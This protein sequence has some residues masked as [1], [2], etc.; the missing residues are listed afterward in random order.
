[1]FQIQT[2]MEWMDMIDKPGHLSMSIY[3]E[4]K[5]LKAHLLKYLQEL[6]PNKNILHVDDYSKV[7]EEFKTKKEA[8]GLHNT[9]IIH[10]DVYHPLKVS[11]KIA[12]TLG[13]NGYI[14]ELI[15]NS[16]DDFLAKN[17]V[18]SYYQY[19][20][21][22]I[23]D[24]K[25][26]QKVLELDVGY[27]TLDVVSAAVLFRLTLRTF[28]DNFEK[29]NL[30]RKILLLGSNRHQPGIKNTLKRVS[31]YIDRGLLISEQQ[32]TVWKQEIDACF[33]VYFESYPEA[34]QNDVCE[35]LCLMTGD[36][37][38]NCLHETAKV[39]SESVFSV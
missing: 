1:M 28:K 14:N 13:L 25:V 21:N 26:F 2:Q 11:K 6:N 4:N 29:S 34:D 5:F 33:K 10:F 15:E 24:G 20:Q 17:V 3:H 30:D 36:L 9:S 18:R 27:D 16:Q 12:D 32:L 35:Q 39:A 19:Y 23:P 31:D 7:I 37:S 22:F 8:L 38:I